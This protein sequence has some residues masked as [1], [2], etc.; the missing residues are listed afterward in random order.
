MVT[1]KYDKPLPKISE[2]VSK[3]VP[4]GVLYCVKCEGRWQN[5]TLYS[6]YWCPKCND[7]VLLA[8]ASEEEL[9]KAIEQ[10]R[11][12]IITLNGQKAN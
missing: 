1:V 7:M 2:E 8:F 12:R 5:D 10:Q 3:S 6:A 9:D 4:H 11:K